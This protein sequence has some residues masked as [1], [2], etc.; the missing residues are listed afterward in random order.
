MLQRDFKIS[1]DRTKSHLSLTLTQDQLNYAI[2]DK[3]GIIIKHHTYDNISFS[4][5]ETYNLLKSNPDFYDS[6]EKKSVI[7]ITGDTHQLSFL[8]ES[9]PNIIPSFEFKEVNIEKI[10]GSLIYNYYG[11]TPAQSNLLDLLLG[12]N[13]YQI[14]TLVF[15]LSS[16]YIGFLQPILHI[17]LEEKIA[18]IYIQKEGKLQFFNSFTNNSAN[19]LLYFI[20]SACKLYEINP[21]KDLKQVSGLIE[22]ESKLF[23]I[24]TNYLNNI[25][26]IVNPDFKIVPGTEFKPH[27]YFTHFMSKSCV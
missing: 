26:F 24:F 11:I 5:T 25:Q 27:Y 4:A 15:G 7:A 14:N 3:D 6:Y 10:P 22:K 9:I 2:I 20:L 13:T 17:H 8:D 19:D 16:Y 1:S 12:K 18:S 23:Q 21:V